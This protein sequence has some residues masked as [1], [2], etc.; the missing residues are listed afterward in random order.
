MVRVLANNVKTNLTGSGRHVTEV[1]VNNYHSP[2]LMA[3]GIGAGIGAAVLQ[4]SYSKNYDLYKKANELAEFDGPY[5]KA[6]Q[7]YQ[8]R[9]VLIGSAA[10][11]LTTGITLWLTGKSE[12]NKVF[13]DCSH[14]DGLKYALAPRYDIHASTIGIQITVSR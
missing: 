14:R 4:S 13:A 10:A 2:W 8:W 11:L 7:A 1:A 5:D 6:N 3:A 12:H 9:N